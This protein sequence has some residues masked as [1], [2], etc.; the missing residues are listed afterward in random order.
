MTIGVSTE[1][2]VLCYWRPIGILTLW[3][4]GDNVSNIIL[5]YSLDG[6]VGKN[7]SASTSMTKTILRT[8][9]QTREEVT[10]DV[11]ASVWETACNFIVSSL[12]MAAPRHLWP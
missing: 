8:T 6:M 10:W 1:H 7:V 4:V 12:N 5:S 3:C 9:C 2:N 11:Y